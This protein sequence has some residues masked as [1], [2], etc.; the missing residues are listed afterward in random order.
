[1]AKHSEEAV[2]S[3]HPG[4]SWEYADATARG[5]ASGFTST[6]L[7]GLAWQQDNDSVWILTATTPTWEQV[8]TGGGSDTDA[9]H[10]NIAN[11]INA[12]TEKTEAARDDV[13]IVEDSDAS[14]AK[15]KVEVGTLGG[16]G[17]PDLKKLGIIASNWTPTI[18]QMY[19]NGNIVVCAT[20]YGDITI[21][22]PD[23]SGF[24]EDDCVRNFRVTNA[25][26]GTVTIQIASSGTF[27]NTDLDKLILN[28]Y[29]QLVDITAYN[30]TGVYTLWGF[31]FLTCE[32]RARRA[33]TWAASNFDTAAAIPFDTE[34]IED[35]NSILEWNVTNAS[36]VTNVYG[37]QCTI[38]YNV[39]ID[40]TGGGNWEAEAWLRKNGTT[41]V[42]GSR[43]K[44]SNAGGK[45]Q[46]ITLPGFSLFLA[47]DDY[48]E[49]MIEQESLTG[50]LHS[51]FI[52]VRTD[53]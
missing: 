18:A 6:D 17:G 9:I 42:S 51:S 3:R 53:I 50:Q 7:G 16:N 37:S 15:K 11:E 23:P 32:V 8:G 38:S 2:G 29:N 27:N 19:A 47:E 43:L 24:P 40:S 39:T 33:A 44:T 41:E 30:K 35:N 14:W 28:K 46:S 31:A 1:M 5:A 12:V 25:G 21:T 36:R 20:D 22:L 4:V 49:I 13:F 26:S 45:D 48:L 10:D 52:T 34:D